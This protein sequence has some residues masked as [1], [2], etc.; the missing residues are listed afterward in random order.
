MI[1]YPLQ[2][3]IYRSRRDETINTVA[4]LSEL[5]NSKMIAHYKVNSLQDSEDTR[6]SGDHCN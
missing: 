5:L 1:V 2:F 4:G 3:K 6:T